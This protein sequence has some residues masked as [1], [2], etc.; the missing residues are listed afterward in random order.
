M[1]SHLTEE[2]GHDYL[3]D[4]IAEERERKLKTIID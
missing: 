3:G 2:F 4:I 1:R